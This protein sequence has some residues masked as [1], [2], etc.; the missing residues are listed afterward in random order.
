[1]SSASAAAG[2]R[3][4][5]PDGSPAGRSSSAWREAFSGTGARWLLVPPIALLAVTLLVPLGFLVFEALQRTDQG[6]RGYAE[7]A[8]DG[9]FHASI[10][11]T[12]LMA[13]IV[14]AASLL[15]GTLYAIAISVA[16]RTLRIFMV[17]ALFTIFWTS[18]LVRTYGW[19]LLYLPQGPL[20]SMLKAL[21]LRETPIDIFQKTIAAYPAM[22][23]VMLPYVVLPVYAA[24]RQ[25]DVMQ[26]RAARVLGAR[27]PLIVRKVLLPQLFPGIAA[28]GVLVWIA[29]LGFYVT[30]QLLGSPRAPM[31][32]GL[33]GNAFDVPG[34]APTGAA[35]SVLLV[36]IVVVVYIGAD[37]AFKVSERWN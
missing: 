18:L 6:A 25:L 28:G 37:R 15:I 9:V 2:L 13:S 10:L 17:I 19:M 5:T 29:S 23:H 21:G 12:L 8:H 35:M 7:V 24:A 33:I 14:A 27:P 36:V 4:R 1:M 31:V 20:Y 16:G 30:P 3:G 11:R 26:V 32:A 22:V 34:G